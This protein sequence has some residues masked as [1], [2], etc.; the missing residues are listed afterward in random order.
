MKKQNTISN[1]NVRISWGGG[2]TTLSLKKLFPHLNYPPHYS[3]K[4]SFSLLVSI[5]LSSLF[6]SFPSTLSANGSSGDSSCSTSSPSHCVYGTTIGGSSNITIGDT[7]DTTDDKKTLTLSNIT[8]GNKITITANKSILQTNNPSINAGAYIIT[9]FKD[10][11]WSGN[12]YINN[13]GYMNISSLTFD[14]TY[15]GDSDE[16]L[17]GYGYS[18]NIDINTGQNIFNFKNSKFGNASATNQTASIN[19]SQQKTYITPETTFNL[20]DSIAQANIVT[21]AAN[22]T[23]NLIN[24]SKWIGNYNYKQ[25][26]IAISSSFTI[27]STN[28]SMTGNIDNSNL[29]GFIDTKNTLN[30]TFSGVNSSDGYS[31][32]GDVITNGFDSTITLKD[33]ARWVGNYTYTNGYMA[34]NATLN[35]K[36]TNSSMT[37]NFTI[38]YDYRRNAVNSN[39]TFSGVNSSDG[40]SLKGNIAIQPMISGGTNTIQFSD[41]AKWIGAGSFNSYGSLTFDN[42]TF[43]GVKLQG[44]EARYNSSILLY[45]GKKNTV[46]FNKSTI[47]GE[48]NISS[49]GEDTL[50]FTDTTIQSDNIDI[51]QGNP[52]GKLTL[53][54]TDSKVNNIT[55][56]ASGILTFTLDASSTKDINNTNTS[57]TLTFANTS[58]KTNL[59]IGNIEFAGKISGTLKNTSLGDIKGGSGL[60]DNLTL[61]ASSTG[62]ITNTNTSSILTIQNTLPASSPS[63]VAP[64]PVSPVVASGDGGDISPTE[65]STTPSQPTFNHT[66]GDIDFA[67]KLSASVSKSSMKSLNLSHTDNSIT[68]KDA[69]ALGKLSINGGSTITTLSDSS[70]GE[71]QITGGDSKANLTASNN[72]KIDTIK[73]IGGTSNITLDNSTLNSFVIDN[74]GKAILS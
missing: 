45:S 46:S 42:S 23:I 40:Y 19:F 17:K 16:S 53:K 14:G 70:I 31:L 47:L 37:G 55:S 65:D 52:S 34:N 7:L 69:S 8:S 73:T 32:K 10:S 12:L 74:G 13:G 49:Y 72:S 50:S 57:S 3:S 9:N 33:N 20:N 29:M 5:S 43:E 60:W 26:N 15:Q 64:A 44:A 28:S 21:T 38:K 48:G 30:L 41:S 61:D 68:L 25:N 59:S 22:Q 1:N 54:I 18:G 11:V 71:I 56:I 27:N 62:N 4:K 36:S 35:I 58:N 51:I 67:G 2:H 66:Y 39:L 63:D 6:F 24:D